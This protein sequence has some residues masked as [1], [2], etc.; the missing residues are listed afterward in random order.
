MYSIS[1]EIFKIASVYSYNSKL[2]YLIN[3]KLQL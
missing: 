2:T 1:H 3:L